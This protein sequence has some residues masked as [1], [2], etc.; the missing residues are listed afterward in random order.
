MTGTCKSVHGNAAD[1]DPAWLLQDATFEKMGVIMA[2]NKGRLLAMF[3][4]R[5][6]FFNKNLAILT[7]MSWL[8]FWSYTMQVH[9]LGQQ[10]DNISLNASFKTCYHSVTGEANFSMQ[11]TN[12]TVGGFNQPSV[13]RFL[14]E[15]PEKN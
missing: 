3:D 13:A 8:C 12:L 9:G 5:S 2:E 14:I 11:S 1:P 10:V 4:E 15:L 6:E 7:P